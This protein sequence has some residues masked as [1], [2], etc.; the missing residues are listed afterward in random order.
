[1]LEDW[2]NDGVALA[3]PVAREA[4]GGW[5]G[6]NTPAR[7]AWRIA[8]QVVEPR[9]ITVPGFLAIPAR[10]RIVPPAT[11]LALA[12]S[13]PAALVHHAAAGHVGMVAGGGA[14]AH[15]WRPLVAWIRA[16]PVPAGL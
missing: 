6:A 15:L 8:G 3:A 7:R 9:G 1:V 10:D 11:A 2:L 16:L 5:Y 4:L 14:E 12:D 13:M